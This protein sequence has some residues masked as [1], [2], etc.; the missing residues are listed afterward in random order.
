MGDIWFRTMASIQPIPP[1]RWRP[2]LGPDLHEHHD[3][4]AWALR[5][6]WRVVGVTLIAQAFLVVASG[7]TSSWHALAGLAAAGVGIALIVAWWLRPL[8]APDLVVDA[9]RPDP[10]RPHIE[11]PT[12]P[13][14]RPVGRRGRT[15]SS[16]AVRTTR[17]RRRG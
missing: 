1:G 2:V 13:R 12:A 3:G 11:F 5:A 7:G 6:A 9:H 17:R 14:V 8:G 15:T 10:T 4:S 16:G